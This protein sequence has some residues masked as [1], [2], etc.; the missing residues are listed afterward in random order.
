VASTLQHCPELRDDMPMS[1]LPTT[2]GLVKRSWLST[3]SHSVS[4]FHWLFRR[5]TAKAT[6][7]PPFPDTITDWPCTTGVIPL[8]KFALTNGRSHSSAPFDT[9]TPTTLPWVIVTSC[10]VPPRSAITGEP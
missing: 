10:R 4:V 6:V 5:A 7:G 9:S 8:V 2:T 1:E 3:F